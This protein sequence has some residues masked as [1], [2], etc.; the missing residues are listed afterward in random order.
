MKIDVISLSGAKS[1]SMELPADLFGL[2]VRADLLHRAVTWQLAGKRAGNANTKTRGEIA[3]TTAR[4]YRQKGTGG[5][6]HGS[7]RVNLFRGGGVVFGPRPRDFAMALPKKVRALALKTALSSKAAAKN[8]VVIDEAVA[9]THKTKDLV[10]QLNK[11]ELNKVLFVVDS[12]DENFDKASRNIPHVKVVPTAGANVYDILRAEKL[13]VTKNA[14]G[15]LQARLNGEE[16]PKAEAKP[17][18]KKAE[19]KKA[20]PKKAPAKKAPKADK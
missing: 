2:P 20:A 11:L 12:V 19:P 15:L 5:A 8:V 13:V 3:R 16:A 4:V 18:A 6:R 7:K 17:A 9:K 1:G 14:I 10:G